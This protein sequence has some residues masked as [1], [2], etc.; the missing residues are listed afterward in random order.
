MPFATLLGHEP[1]IAGLRSAM[2][3]DRV[4]HAYL[5]AGPDG[6]GKARAAEAFVQLL[7]CVARAP[8]P[9][10][11][12]RCRP[13]R[14]IADGRHPDLVT[15]RRD[16][17]FIKIEQ[18]REVT[19]GV[20]FPPVE[21]ATRAVI[22]HDA[23]ALHPTA[24]NALLKTLEEPSQR[25]VFVL[26]TSQPNVLLTTIRSR[27]QQVRFTALDRELV[28]A[29]LVREKGIDPETADE[30]AA[31]SGGSLSAAERLVDVELGAL[32]EQW[33]GELCGLAGQ[34]PTGLLELGETLAAAKDKLP[35]VLDVLRSAL[36][37]VL[38]K[39]GG[40]SADKLTFRGRRLPKMDAESALGALGLIDEAERALSG[41]VN[42][43][44]VAEH[45]L[46]GLR[47]ATA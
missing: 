23:E 7:S 12:G 41:N 10:A 18:V 47:R 9:D 43:R 27:C 38:L 6:V 33:L 45:L 36:R 42:A 30:L 29:W 3:R 20:R 37:D 15:V 25:N 21:A 14:L 35:A 31:M 8:G 4:A 46:L 1:V 13:C 17:Q 28:A 16:G 40:V 11:C 26:V 39:A 44:L 24:A 34:R 5:F 32:R 19:R 22:I 2:E